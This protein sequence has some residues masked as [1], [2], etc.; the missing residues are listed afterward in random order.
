MLHIA[1]RVAALPVN[2]LLLGETGS[3]KDY[4]AEI[5]HRVG[6]RRA[7]PFLRIDCGA[8]PH[9]LFESEL[10]GYEKGA[11]TDARHAKRGR[12]ELAAGGTVYLDEI[13]ALDTTL[14]PKLLRLLQER[15]FSR[16]GGAKA[17]ELDA[18]FIASTTLSMEQLGR[19]DGVRPDLFYRLNVVSIEIPPLRARR[20]D[21]APLA[22]SFREE[23]AERLQRNVRAFHPDAMRALQ[24]HDW[25]GNLRELKHVVERAVILAPREEIVLEDLPLAA[26]P[27][28]PRLVEAAAVEEWTL[29][30][31][32]RFYIQQVLSATGQNYSRASEIL[33]INRK[34]LLE[35]RKRYGL[36]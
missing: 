9:E 33:G 11:F 20:E 10:F 12:L 7:A 19:G 30:E 25:P 13:A 26:T 3:G 31:L 27:R 36:D 18:R 23:S 16:I 14:Q 5:I 4:L 35:K 15:R 24:N 6:P 32:E 8:I 34:T 22:E 2:V 17:L 28:G 29:E 1:E 21:I